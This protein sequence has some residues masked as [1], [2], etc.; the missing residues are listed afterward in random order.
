MYFKL[1]ILLPC[2][3]YITICISCLFR[4]YAPWY[5]TYVYLCVC[6]VPT[7]IGLWSWFRLLRA[8]IM[9]RINN[10][11]HR[12]LIPSVIPSGTQGNT[13]KYYLYFRSV[14]VHLGDRGKVLNWPTSGIPHLG[15]FITSRVLE[16]SSPVTFSPKN[17]CI[18]WILSLMVL[19]FFILKIGSASV[20][21]L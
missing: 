8:T 21:S 16:S 5:T 10:N 1:N 2:C 11:K 19:L 3:L 14:F 9:I 4:Q 15:C 18:S 6:L 20:L 7:T 12:K 13:L 17:A